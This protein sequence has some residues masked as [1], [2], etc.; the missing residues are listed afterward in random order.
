MLSE[1]RVT[2]T[3][4]Y[5]YLGSQDFYMSYLDTR[6]LFKNASFEARFNEIKIVRTY[7]KPDE[8]LGLVGGVAFFIVLVTRWIGRRFNKLKMYVRLGD[9]MMW[10]SKEA[11]HLNDDMDKPKAR[12]KM[13]ELTDWEVFKFSMF[14]FLYEGCCACFKDD[15]RYKQATILRAN[16]QYE[17]DL[18]RLMRTL[19]YSRFRQSQTFMPK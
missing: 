14:S 2:D 17:L 13:L 15:L 19:N 18:A 3:Y 11:Q 16:I 4:D 1:P 7:Y 6:T 8:V 9:E 10:S 12:K 5:T